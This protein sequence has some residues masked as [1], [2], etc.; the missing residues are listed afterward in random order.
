MT[1]RILLLVVVAI[2]IPACK[3]NPAFAPAP[4][5]VVNAELRPTQVVPSSGVPVATTTATLMIAD[6]HRSIDYSVTYTGAGV[7]TAVEIRSGVAGRN[8]PVL[9]ILATAPFTNPLVGTLT[10][11]DLIFAPSQ[12]ILGLEAAIAAITNGETYIL[13][14][15]FG[16]PTGEMRGQL[17][18]ATLA[19]AVMSGAQEVPPVAGTGFGTFTL[20]FDPTQATM[21]A[22]LTFSGLTGPVPGTAADAAHIH[23]GAAGVGGG[24]IIF[25]L[26]TVPF[27]SPLVVTLDIG[28]FITDPSVVTFADAIDAL[29]TGN[30]YVNVHTTAN[31]GGEIRGQIG[32]ARLSASLAGGS[33]APPVVTAA[34]GSADLVLNASQTELLVLLTHTVGTPQSARI[35]TEDPGFN[36]PLLFDVDAIAGSAASPLTA[37]LNGT[38]LI[39]SPPRN[40][41]TFSDFVNAL[42][43]SKTYL[44]VGS[45]SFPS[46]EIRGQ[47]VP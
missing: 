25:D 4:A 11:S 20:A 39:P 9:F 36:G 31:P 26:S 22:T 8:G 16:D 2:L 45:P 6:G 24:P 5:V 40:I 18:A 14:S 37:T 13:I 44:D 33:V 27:T 21:T 3:I 29:L 32:P 23:F 15:T 38:Q 34:T 42:L 41:L 7:I 46:G 12:G 43:T 30:M 35:F 19:S 1:R 28:D 10:E 17:G 47:I